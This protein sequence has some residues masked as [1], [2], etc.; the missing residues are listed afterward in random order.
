MSLI[1][2]TDDSIIDYLY[3]QI[4]YIAEILYEIDKAMSF[5]ENNNLE[6]SR[7]F[8]MAVI[9]Y[10][11]DN[12]YVSGIWGVKYINIFERDDIKISKGNLNLTIFDHVILY[13]NSHVMYDNN[14]TT[15]IIA[16]CVET[17]I[18]QLFKIIF[19]DTNSDKTKLAEIFIFDDDTFT[20]VTNIINEKN[21]KN[22]D[23]L[24][25]WLNILYK[26]FSKEIIEFKQPIKDPKVEIRATVKNI[27]TVLYIYC[28]DD[29]KDKLFKNTGEIKTKENVNIDTSDIFYTELLKDNIKD[30][31]HILLKL[32]NLIVNKLEG[33]NS[34]NLIV[35][36]INS[37]Y[38]EYIYEIKLKDT[39]Y[40][41]LIRSYKHA[42]LYYKN[43]KTSFLNIFTET[44]PQQSSRAKPVQLQGFPAEP[45][46]PKSNSVI[47]REKRGKRN[48]Q[49]VR[50]ELSRQYSQDSQDSDTFS[51]NLGGGA[52]TSD[53]SLDDI[54]IECTVPECYSNIYLYILCK[55]FFN[56]QILILEFLSI[57]NLLYNIW[58]D[59][60]LIIKKYINNITIRNYILLKFK[61]ILDS[62]IIIKTWDY[63]IL[64]NFLNLSNTLPVP[65][66]NEILTKI[67][68]D[69][70]NLIT[71]ISYYI[72]DD[73]KIFIDDT[74][75]IIY[76]D[77]IL[78]IYNDQTPEPVERLDTYYRIISNITSYLNE[79]DVQ[80]NIKCYTLVQNYL[81]LNFPSISNNE[82]F[83]IHFLK[84]INNNYFILIFIGSILNVDTKIFGYC[85]IN[86]IFENRDIQKDQIIK[87]INTHFKDKYRTFRFDYIQSQYV[88]VI[89]KLGENCS[90]FKNNYIYEYL[91]PEPSKAASKYLKYKNK[92]LKLKNKLKN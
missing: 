76:L 29:I 65:E 36:L 79:K 60:F 56:E 75:N 55:L 66:R 18:L 22:I 19:N 77:I 85:I 8:L 26:K 37:E 20:F 89:N 73:Y 4:I 1:D 61:R 88:A 68:N 35:E 52:L 16:N 74:L 28:T 91:F 58:V 46:Y 34:I 59:F 9:S 6:Y 84:N 25:E 42:A 51:L 23:K 12:R 64:I 45:V 2:S 7:L 32:L 3:D 87:F 49:T 80:L 78:L 67:F 15:Y 86:E 47:K 50:R 54:I 41:L 83:I 31:E 90:I 92:Y 62:M 14:G 44:I 69:N 63:N 11:L 13:E 30:L 57:N 70:F 82:K 43:M 39:I 27:F 40:E 5:D 53:D 10:R 38:Y 81:L 24:K 17:T 33:D 72:S 48:I 21:E 71:I